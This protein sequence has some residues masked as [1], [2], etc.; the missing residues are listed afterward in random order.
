MSSR[1]V[2]RFLIAFAAYAQ[3]A[4]TTAEDHESMLTEE[5]FFE[6]MPTVLSATR[7][8]QPLSEAPVAMTVIDRDMIAA[9]T[10]TH[11]AE[12]LRLAPGFQVTYLEGIDTVSTYH[13]FA[14]QFPKRMQVLIDGRSAY[15]P[16]LQ[17][18][19]WASLP[20]T[21]N[22]IERIEVVRGP[23]A[24]VFGSNAFLGTIN[25][26]TRSREVRDTFETRVMAGSAQTREVEVSAS[27]QHGKF[28]I[29]LTA[30]Y[31]ENDGFV[32]K[33]DDNMTRL[34]NFSGVYRP[35][36]HDTFTFQAGLRDTPFDSELFRIPRDRRYR[37]NFQQLIWER[38][39]S[40][41]QDLRVQIYHNGFESPDDV[42]FIDPGSGLPLNLDYSLE[43]DRYDFE[44]QHRWQ[45]SDS[46]RMSW[47][48][49]V[50]R[51]II[52]GEGIYDTSADIERDVARLFA[53]VEWRPNNA[54]AINAGLMSEHFS[55]FGDYLSPR[56]ATNWHFAPNQTLRISAARAYRVPTVLEERGEV[57][58]DV[59][60]T[61]TYPDL[62]ELLGTAD[63]DAEQIDSIELGYIVDLPSINGV[64]D[65]R[66]FHNEIENLLS[67]VTDQTLPGS[68]LRYIEAGSFRTKGVEL[69]ANLR[70]TRDWLVHLAYSYA[71][72]YGTYE[73]R[74]ARE[75]GG[76]AP[77]PRE[78]DDAVP[79]HTLTLLASKDL[80]DGWRL[81][82][83][84]YHVSAM[85]WLGEGD[86][87]KRQTRL[88]AKLAKRFRHSTGDVELA[89]NVQNLFNDDYYEFTP[90]FPDVGVNGNL[91]ERR[92]YA[93]IRMNFH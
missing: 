40:A 24:A 10:A 89:L 20:L 58:V 7:L 85:E 68:P 69:Q 55:D 90:S 41:T 46:W 22:D 76:F 19:V 30:A 16:G 3:A 52:S 17:G 61:P 5:A 9:S 34:M 66:L 32:D 51:D 65:V 59:L 71:R 74:I 67:E 2:S 50:R 38:D 15:D 92:V 11:I 53:N 75:T 77:N 73:R 70:P 86:N 29:G 47:G 23:N 56:L 8:V 64:V 37:S 36:S 72:T 35:S 45:F 88:D 14:D 91:G 28:A 84:G 49:G 1:C 80:G 54:V 18:T 33:D 60:V 6:G 78:A 87:V 21:I 13:G 48:G 62:I 82:G 25:I 39:L 43:T 44:L 26:I 57:K 27:K 31:A 81:S 4:A 93:E 83:T 63:N 42:D 79:R 12:L